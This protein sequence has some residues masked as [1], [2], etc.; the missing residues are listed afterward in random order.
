MKSEVRLN[1]ATV[2]YHARE[3]GWGWGG[4]VLPPPSPTA[5]REPRLRA[6]RGTR[7]GQA[8]QSRSPRLGEKNI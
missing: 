5:Q 3:R 6:L 1:G 8:A 4:D 7:A 2:P